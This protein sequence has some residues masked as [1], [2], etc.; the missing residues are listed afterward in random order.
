MS[1]G[2]VSGSASLSGSLDRRL[3]ATS[4]LAGSTLRGLSLAAGVAAASLSIVPAMGQDFATGGGVNN[5]S[6]GNATAIGAGATTTGAD[7]TALMFVVKPFGRERPIGAI[8][9]GDGR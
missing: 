4:A 6:P 5:T 1:V 9:L 7:A 3:L 8:H 2:I